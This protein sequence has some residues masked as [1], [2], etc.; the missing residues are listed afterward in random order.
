MIYTFC[1]GLALAGY[2]ARAEKGNRLAYSPV[3]TLTAE[4][5]ECLTS[6]EFG[7]IVGP[8]KINWCTRKTRLILAAPR[9]ERFSLFLVYFSSIRFASHLNNRLGY[10]ILD[11]GG[12]FVYS[13]FCL[14]RF[15]CYDTFSHVGSVYIHKKCWENTECLYN[16]LFKWC[17]FFRWKS[18]SL[19]IIETYMFYCWLKFIVLHSKFDNVLSK[20]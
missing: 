17:F 8:R 2:L 16:S 14:T 7:R 5:K 13:V 1:R 12:S 20:I 3:F 11:L 10:L 9:V 4:Q 6:K 19:T 18:M 15:D